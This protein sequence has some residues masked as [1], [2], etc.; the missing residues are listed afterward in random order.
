MTRE[1]EERCGKVK[2]LW[3]CEVGLLCNEEGVEEVERSVKKD[4]IVM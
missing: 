2:G 4:R 1:D 3:G